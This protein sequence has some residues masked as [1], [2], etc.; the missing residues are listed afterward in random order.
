MGEQNFIQGWVV[1]ALVVIF[2]M[3]VMMTM[4]FPK[5]MGAGDDYF[6]TLTSDRTID[7][8]SGDYQNFTNAIGATTEQPWCLTGIYTPY[9][10]DNNEGRYH[11][12]PD[13]WIYS[14]KITRYS[15]S[16]Y[17][18]TEADH[19][20][21][22]TASA[23]TVQL[24]LDGDSSVYRYGELGDGE[25]TQDGH[26]NG[27]LYSYVTMDINQQSDI[28]FTESL[29]Q[30]K[31]SQF[32]YEYTGYRYA[33]QPLSDF[34]TPGESGKPVK[35]A[36]VS[37]SLSLIWYNFVG[38]SGIS[39]QLVLTG[40]DSG[41]AYITANEILT[42][43]NSINNTA[44]FS[45][46]F[47]SCEMSVY[48]RINPYYTAQGWSIE[49]CYNNGWWSIMVAAITT[50]PSAYTTPANPLNPETIWETMLDLFTFNMDDYPLSDVM[51]IVAS[52]MITIVMYSALLAIAAHNPKLLIIVA[53]IALIQTVI[54]ILSNISF[55]NVDWT[56]WIPWA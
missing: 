22:T 50:N 28:F 26:K 27:D 21:D 25:Y 30:T 56:S 55:E 14:E 17:L 8:L 19:P 29:K 38:S 2:L 32:L 46:N 23:Y 10:F 1:V 18:W 15:P 12:T 11:Y 52:L 9:Q 37:T 44:R 43:F 54:S 35:I 33:F 34:Y 3:P 13:N 5:E 42:A 49:D 4:F 41:V 51:K 16:Q 45:M 47:N 6:D 36:A 48:I 20:V 40:S 53:I 24:R 31:G 7:Q 39:G